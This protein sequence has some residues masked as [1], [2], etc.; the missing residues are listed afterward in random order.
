[1][2]NM[3]DNDTIEHL[4]GRALYT[5]EHIGW[6][7]TDRNNDIVTLNTYAEKLFQCNRKDVVGKTIR[8]LHYSDESYEVFFQ[9]VQ[10]MILRGEKVQMEYPMRNRHG[11]KLCLSLSGQM[12][13][14]QGHKLWTG[15]D[16]TKQK[17][18][19]QELSRMKERLEYAIEG[20]KDIVWDWDIRHRKF[21]ISKRWR[22]LTGYSVTEMPRKISGLQRLVYPADRKKVFQSIRACLN[23]RSH[24]LDVTY[25]LERRDGEIVWISSRAVTLYDDA[26]TAIRMVGTHRDITHSKKL[27]FRLLQQA[28]TIEEQRD[29]LWY[30]AHHDVLTE[31]P[32]RIYFRKLLEAAIEEAQIQQE[33]LAVL[34]VDL[35]NFKTI[36]DTCGHETGDSVLRYT[37]DLLRNGVRSGD[38]VARL[39]GDEFVLIIRNVPDKRTIK[40]LAQK[41]L[42]LFRKPYRTRRCSLELSVSIGIALYP[43]D[44]L[45]SDRLLRR[46]DRAMYRVKQTGRGNWQ[47]YGE[48]EIAENKKNSQPDRAG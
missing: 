26:G 1:M 30:R 46:A 33:R 43:E 44:G 2:C 31:L 17:K 18:V 29:K 20:S 16:I 13:D 28:Q 6:V 40:N 48:M 9:K 32:N 5:S 35:D 41:L 15:I 27:E 19:E 39:G 7:I 21:D 4:I 11:E 23:G 12:L 36:N 42:N 38:V 47:C 45:Q 24:Y 34:F 37:A 8:I 10:E 3:N 25:R 22:E 14:D